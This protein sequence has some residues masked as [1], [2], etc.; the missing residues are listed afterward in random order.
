MKISS[1][2]THTSIFPPTFLQLDKL[3][4]KG[5]YNFLRGGTVSPMIKSLQMIHPKIAVYEKF[6]A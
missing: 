3:G 5:E 6:T 4:T 2:K 1:I